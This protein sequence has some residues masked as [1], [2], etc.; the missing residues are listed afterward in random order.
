MNAEQILCVRWCPRWLCRNLI[1]CHC[2]LMGSGGGNIMDRI[3]ILATKLDLSDHYIKPENKCSFL[4]S[5]C[6]IQ[7]SWSQSSFFEINKWFLEI[8]S[9]LILFTC[10]EMPPYV[11]LNIIVRLPKWVTI[12]K[13]V[14]TNLF[15]FHLKQNP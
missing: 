7:N 11:K 5:I 8:V 2:G 10:V 4:C 13:A 1:S 6:N 14:H 15:M 9:V 12:H 3:S